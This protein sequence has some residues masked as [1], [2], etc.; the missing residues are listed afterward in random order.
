[1]PWREATL[2]GQRVLARVRADG[3][4]EQKEGRVEIRYRATDPRA[5]HARAGNLVLGDG[6]VLGDGEVVAA[7]APAAK[8][9]AK[10]TAAA[11]VHAD[12][13]NSWIA[14]TDGACTGNPGPA[15]S[16]TVLI[17]PGGKISETYDYLGEGT[18]NI[19]ELTAVLRALERTPSAES[20]VLHTD[21]QYAI[22]VLTKGWKAKANVAL[23]EKIRGA[24]RGRD[25]RFVY[26]PGHAG[27]PMNERADELAREA[28][29]TRSSR[30]E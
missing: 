22:G 14:Y 2:R 29:K 28:I 15:G 12:Y 26:V 7:G 16:G 10:K 11:P 18:N 3:T 23:I 21:S 6:Q 8:K 13:K 19:A 4:F 24:L 17:A 9:A 27:V 5:Y 30:S 20:L 25:V 1:M